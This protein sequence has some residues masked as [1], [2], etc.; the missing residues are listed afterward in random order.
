MKTVTFRVPT[1][2]Y[3]LFGDWANHLPA[4]WRKRIYN[5][6]KVASSLT[7]LALVIIP[8]LPTILPA[9]GLSPDVLTLNSTERFGAIATATLAFVSHLAATNT[10][11]EDEVDPTK[12]DTGPQP[13]PEPLPSMPAVPMAAEPLV[14]EEPA[15]GSTGKPI[16]KVQIKAPLPDEPDAPTEV[17][18]LTPPRNVASL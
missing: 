10:H 15:L 8:A 17:T 6:L 7:T 13:P 3:V 14:E 1:A 2:I 11:P 9:F 18:V 4:R 5:T 16:A 12:A